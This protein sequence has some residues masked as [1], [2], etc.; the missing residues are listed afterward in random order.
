MIYIKILLL[1]IT[2]FAFLRFTGSY[3]PILLDNKRLK[4][5]VIRIFPALE[6]FV[7][8]GFILWSSSLIFS[9]FAAFPVIMTFVVVIIMATLAWYLL[10]DFISGIILRSENGFEPDQVIKTSFTQGTIKRIGY[11]SLEIITANGENVK[12][13]YTM[14]MN[15]SVI[16]PQ[17]NSKWRENVIT[18]EV[19]TLLDSAIVKQM[20]K[21]RLMEM[22]WIV[23]QES[24]KIEL[25]L[26]NSHHL[27]KEDSSQDSTPKYSVT[28]HFYSI[29]PETAI[30]TQENLRIF[31]QNN[32]F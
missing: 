21:K 12:I 17:D 16:K 25:A 10:R 30:K 4:S 5:Y 23:S 18:L 24:I 31:V 29:T 32:F 6:L 7:W 14:L 8:L 13:P 1:A 22:P 28:V 27:L 15:T 9:N 20:L 11:R 19:A 2:L 26:S 3:L